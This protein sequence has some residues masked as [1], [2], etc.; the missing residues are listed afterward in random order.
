MV[1][2]LVSDVFIG[3]IDEVGLWIG[4]MAGV[5]HGEAPEKIASIAARSF[6]PP[7]LSSRRLRRGAGFA[8]F[9]CSFDAFG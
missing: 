1:S 9:I 3:G 7:P 5:R 8:F 2:I 4:G 6:H